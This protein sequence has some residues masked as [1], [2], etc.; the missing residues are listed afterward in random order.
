M[1]GMCTVQITSGFVAL[2][3]IDDKLSEHEML[4]IREPLLWTIALISIVSVFSGLHGGIKYLSLAAVSLAV[5][6]GFLVFANDDSKFVLNLTVQA[7]GY[8][9]QNSL[10]LLNFWTDAFGQLPEGSG[11]AVDGKAAE[12]GW[13]S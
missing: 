9:I 1:L 13:M 8:H 10:F 2:G 11:R 4:S 3:W 6:L 5:L 12:E 7:V